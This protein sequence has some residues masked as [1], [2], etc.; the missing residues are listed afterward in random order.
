MGELPTSPILALR[1]LSFRI[2]ALPARETVRDGDRGDTSAICYRFGRQAGTG[3]CDHGN[4]A[5]VRLDMFSD[6]DLAALQD[7]GVEI[8]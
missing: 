2:A 8:G 1:W 6:T 7:K 3:G 5:F 4:N